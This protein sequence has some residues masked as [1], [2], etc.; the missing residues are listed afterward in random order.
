MSIL[1]TIHH[2][3]D[4]HDVTINSSLKIREVKMFLIVSSVFTIHHYDVMIYFPLKIREDV[5]DIS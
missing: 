4:D 5:P 3:I 2:L 1:L